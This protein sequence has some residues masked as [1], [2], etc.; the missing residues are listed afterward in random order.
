MP[1]HCRT[2][3]TGGV[4]AANRAGF[5]VIVPVGTSHNIINTGNIPLKLYTLYALPNHRD[6]GFH[7]TRAEVDHEHLDGKTME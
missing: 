3:K 6:G 5:A 7:S 2:R 4:H 1:D